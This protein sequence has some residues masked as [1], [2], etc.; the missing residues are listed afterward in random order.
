MEL[1]TVVATKRVVG[2][3]SLALGIAACAPSLQER[4]GAAFDKHQYLEAAT[5]YDAVVHAHPDDAHARARLMTARTLVIREL[6]AQTAVARTSG[7]EEQ[8]T[9]TLSQVLGDRDAWSM[10]LPDPDH[11]ALTVE[12]VAASGYIDRE[13]GRAT[14]SAGPLSGEHRLGELSGLLAHADFART[15]SQITEGVAA[16]GRTACELLAPQATTPY[17]SWVVARYC[18]HWQ[19]VPVTMV[20]R[21]NLHASLVVDGAIDGASDADTVRVRDALAEAFHAS[22]WFGGDGQAPVRGTLHGAVAAAFDAQ[23]VSRTASWTESVPYTAY[24]TTQESYQEP[25]DD[26][27]TYS[28]QVPHTE[29]RTQTNPCGDTTC[30]ETVPETVYTTEWKTRS[31]TRYRTAYRDVTNPVT[32]YR[33]EPRSFTYAA[34]ERTGRY[35]SQLV[36][37]IAGDE[38]AVSAAVADDRSEHG[39]DHDVT[40]VA[41]G[42]SPER[43]NLTQL[44]AFVAAEAEALQAELR[45]RL[46]ERYRQLYCS[47]SQYALEDAAACAY[48]D[49]AHAPAAVHATL[50]SVFG[51]DERWLGDVLARR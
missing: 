49:A 50:A 32:R 24:E 43:A 51:A 10:A 42:V 2:I 45:A 16:A 41:A 30:T 4:A 17:W 27:E 26:T 39:F 47:A 11:L 23:T 20:P 7:H 1:R 14:R 6:L 19:G 46:D 44:P 21:P 35:T 48:L 29:Y 36:V 13:V 34:L 33:D 40:N 31:V 38:P 18:T 5:L 15:R 37:T 8:A 3:V 9:A 25:Y 22:V 12:V 28:E